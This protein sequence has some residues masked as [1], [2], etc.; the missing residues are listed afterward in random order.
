MAVSRGKEFETRVKTA[1]DLKKSAWVYRLHDQM[2]G[3]INVS[4]NPCDFLVHEQSDLYLVECKSTNSKSFPFSALSDYQYEQ[5]L[6]CYNKTNVWGRVI[7]WYVNEPSDDMSLPNTFCVP[8]PLITFVE[9]HLDKKS[10]NYRDMLN[11]FEL[12]YVKA[13]DGKRGRIYTEYSAKSLYDALTFK[14]AL[15]ME[16]KQFRLSRPEEFR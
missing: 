8:M 16:E 4:K 14:S 11:F 1:L 12:G 2:S 9:K 13:I 15:D 10:I 7:V 3:R 5:L 6:E